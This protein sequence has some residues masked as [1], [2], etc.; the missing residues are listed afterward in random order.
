MFI[1]K[2]NQFINESR[3]KVVNTDKGYLDVIK[4][5][6][7]WYINK[8]MTE[9]PLYRGIKS[10]EDYLLIDSKGHNRKPV[11]NIGSSD[12]PVPLYYNLIMNESERWRRFPGYIPRSESIFCTNDINATYNYGRDSEGST[13]RVIPLEENTE[14]IMG[15]TPDTYGSFTYINKRFGIDMSHF[16]REITRQLGLTNWDY[17]S[18]NEMKKEIE[19]IYNSNHKTSENVT[20]TEDFM[21]FLNFENSK[22]GKDREDIITKEELEKEGGLMKWI[23]KMFDPELNQFESVKYNSDIYFGRTNKYNDRKYTQFELWTN[24][25]CLLVNNKFFS[26]SN[27]N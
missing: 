2:Y 6:A 21:Q 17:N 10:N 20:L 5:Y 3:S 18:L 22:T 15:F 4:E 8:D 19:S 9:V 7:P 16:S 13:Y 14:F 25:P 26:G 27:W 1:K 24:K 11:G 12:E 23:E